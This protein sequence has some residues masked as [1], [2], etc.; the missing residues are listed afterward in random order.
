M[1]ELLCQLNKQDRT[2]MR[3]CWIRKCAFHFCSPG[4]VRRSHAAA[5]HVWALGIFFVV[6]PAAAAADTVLGN[7]LITKFFIIN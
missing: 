2:A 3:S 7:M 5:W 6:W 1:F 4:V